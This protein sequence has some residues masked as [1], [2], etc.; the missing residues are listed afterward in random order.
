MSCLS[1]SST[2]RLNIEAGIKN[3]PIRLISLDEFSSVIF[4]QEFSCEI[5]MSFASDSSTSFLF[6]VC[7]LLSWSWE[8]LP[9]TPATSSENV[10]AV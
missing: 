7:V 5:L 4:G 2:T 3:S 9:V 8:R 10:S 6:R 1:D